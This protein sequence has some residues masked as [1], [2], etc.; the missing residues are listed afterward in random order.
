MDELVLKNEFARRSFRDVA[1]Q[2]YI[3][4]RL[5]HRAHLREP[6]LWSSLQAIEKYLKAI[7]LF[8]NKSSK[9]VGHNLEEALHRVKCIED[10]AFFIPDEAQKF[11]QYLNE[12]GAN[13]YLE[14]STHLRQHAIL[15]LDMT[16]WHIRKYCFY[17][18]GISTINSR[19]EIDWLP[20]N[21]AKINDNSFEKYPHKYQLFGGLL[22]DI[23][24]K[25]SPAAEP[26]IWHNFYYGRKNKKIIQNYKWFINASNSVLSR[27]PEAFGALDKLVHFSKETRNHFKN[28]KS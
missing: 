2:D 17:M 15:E 14:H 11:I 16:V 20:L 3:A 22:E 19:K 7:L 23:I 28:Q 27:H 10:I 25:N 13:R 9:G 21:I 5:S 18:R 8:N 4:A 1:D 6:F 12:Y 24:K 26:L